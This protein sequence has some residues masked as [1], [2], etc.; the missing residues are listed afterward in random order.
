MKQKITLNKYNNFSDEIIYKTVLKKETLDNKIKNTNNL[1]FYQDSFGTS[2][3]EEVSQNY[4]NN[5]SN[6]SGFIEES[7]STKRFKIFK[8]NLIYQV[9]SAKGKKSLLISSYL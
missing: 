9:I 8:K 3:F 7:Y 2:R 1:L 6:K 5:F 4:K